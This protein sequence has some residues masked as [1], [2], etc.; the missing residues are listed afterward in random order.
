MTGIRLIPLC[1][2]LLL[3]AATVEAQYPPSRG[4]TTSAVGELFPAS[5]DPAAPAPA[6]A[7][8]GST[9]QLVCRGSADVKFATQ[10]P[11]PR[12]Q[13]LAAVTLSYARNTVPPGSGYE[14][15]QPGVCSWNPSLTSATPAEPGMVHFDVQREGSAEIPTPAT[16]E[17]WLQDPRHYWVFY[18]ND[19]TNVSIS[20]GAY[21]GRFR[22]EGTP[23]DKQPTTKPAALRRERLRC[24][25]GGG[26]AFS[27]R[28]RE[29]HNE[30][31]MTLDYQVAPSAAGPV[32]G[33]LSPGSCA[34]ADRADAPNE[35]GRIEFTTAGNAQLKQK[36]SGSAVDT[37]PT[38]A[39]RWP[40][41]QTIPAYM[42]NPAHYWTFVVSLPR[43]SA[44]LRHAAWLPSIPEQIASEPPATAPTIP[45]GQGGAGSASGPTGVTGRRP[46]DGSG[47]SREYP[48]SGGGDRYTPGTGTT[49][50]PSAIFDIRNVEVKSGLE[51]VAIKFEAAAGLSPTVTIATRAPAGSAGNQTFDGQAVRL[52]VQGM[53]MDGGFSRYSAASPTPLARGTQYWFI[54]EAPEGSNSRRN[55]TTGEFRTLTQRLKVGVSHI[56]VVSDGDHDSPGDLYFSLIACPDVISGNLVG[57]SY[58]ETVEWSEGRHPVGLEIT[59][60]S[61]VT[62][63]DRIRLF[64]VGLENDG[65]LFSPGGQRSPL[66]NYYYCTDP[67]TTFTP[68]STSRGEWNAAVIDLDLTQYAGSSNTQTFVRRSQPLRNGTRV[69]FEVRGHITVTRE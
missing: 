33:G 49:F 5:P 42:G 1:G 60:D 36:Q 51:G 18:V 59:S 30:V 34:W 20:H 39:E 7:P 14:Q 28:G 53:A 8:T 4:R 63:P 31:G 35:P 66:S 10:D 37:S 16:L 56:D 43:P 19:A 47:T 48:G 2:S 58:F 38:A 44:A 6:P 13:R 23:G 21:G 55:Q 3:L 50:N 62:V 67:A 9:R 61:E 25:G 45:G 29:G 64:L 32:G 57:K 41:A 22:V 15:L 68:Y 17:Y 69:S 54:A 65:W 24:R 27:R 11:S 46:T 52:A 26:L 12:D 40:D